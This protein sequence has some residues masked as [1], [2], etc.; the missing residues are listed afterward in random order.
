MKEETDEDMLIRYI[1][2][3]VE[4]TERETIELW[5]KQDKTNGRKLEQVKFILESSEQLAQQSP[6]NEDDQWQKFKFK[7]EAL[8]NKPNVR[9]ISRR[10]TWLQ[11]AAAILI[12]I[13]GASAAY[14][15]YNQQVGLNSAGQSFAS[16]DK[17]L[18]DTLSDG[19]IVHL[20]RYSSV[21]CLGDFKKTREVRLIGEA[22]FE[23]K[24]NASVPFIVHA[25]QVNIR[26]IGTAFNVKSHTKNVEVVVE[27][28]IVRVTK[29]RASVQLN[30][31]QKV[32]VNSADMQLHVEKNTDQLYNYYRSNEFIANK[33]QLW[34]VIEIINEAYDSHIVI[35]DKRLNDLPLTGN[36]KKES[37][38]KFL[39]VLL[40]STPDIKME[41]V[42]DNIILKRK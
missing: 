34:R 27:S 15:F 13:S 8:N 20:N 11:M 23:V 33:T 26:D 30:Q 7:R 18:I 32:M 2:G 5:L 24:H 14:Y 39:E 17:A 31:Q 3:E 42:G 29:E 10:T 25:G 1:L 41:K 35:A 6:A 9:S 19:S 4:D 12:F 21:T 28:G 16:T 22:F 40:L 38:D 36:F 37:V